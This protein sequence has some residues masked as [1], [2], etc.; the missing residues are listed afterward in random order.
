MAFLLWYKRGCCFMFLLLALTQA[1]AQKAISL[2]GTV[3]PLRQYAAQ[4]LQRYLYQLSGEWLPI[5]KQPV[6]EGFVIAAKNEGSLSTKTFVTD[7]IGDQGY[8]LKKLGNQLHI[9]ANTAV[10]CLYGVYGLLDD[11]YD[12]GFYFS[13]DVLP[14]QKKAFF[15]PEVNEE[16]SPS[17]YIRGFLPW[18]N[19]PQSATIYSWE[20]WR[21]II[22]QAAK[23][24]MNFIHIHNYNG[25]SGHNE[26]YHNFEYKGILSRVWMPTARTGHRWSMKGFDVKD[27]R[28]GAEDLVGD[29]DMGSEVGLH[30]ETLDNKAVFAKGVNLFQRVI[31][32]AHERGVKIGLGLDIDLIM[33]DYKTTPDDPEVIKAR[34]EQVLNDYPDL[35]Y[36]ILFISELINEQPEKL[37]QWRRIF[38]GMYRIVNSRPQHPRIA[39]AGWGLNAAIANDLPADVIAAPISSYSDGFEPGAIYGDR[40]YW[41]CPWMERDFFSSEYYYPYN[42]HLHNTVQAWQQR[43]PNMKGLYTLSWRLTDAVDPR[44]SFI[45]KAA[46]DADN[47]YKTAGAVYEEYARRNYGGRAASAIAG[48]LNNNEPASIATAECE[49]TAAFTGTAFWENQNLTNLLRFQFKKGA[50]SSSMLDYK[51]R[52]ALHNMGIDNAHSPLSDSCFGWIKEGSWVRYAGVDLRAGFDSMTYAAATPNTEVLVEVRLDSASGTMI[53]TLPLQ[54]TGGWHNWKEQRA[55]VQSVKGVH[56]V[57]FVVRTTQDHSVDPVQKAM[58][59]IHLIDSL[60]AL[61]NDAGQKTRM[62]W[63]KARLAAAAD[64]VRL[65]QYFPS[66]EKPGDLPG[67]FPSWVRNFTRRIS[68]ISSLGN[69]QSIQNRYV[70]ENYLAKEKELLQKATVKFPTRVKARGTK[71]GALVTW[72]NNEPA[73]KGFVVMADGKPLH[74]GWLAPGVRSFHHRANGQFKYQVA[75]VSFAGMFSEASEIS[76]C[77]AGNTDKEGPQIV[78]VSPPASL[79]GVEPFEIKASLLDNRGYAALHAVLY[80]RY[81]GEKTWRQSP[82]EWR[83]KAIFTARL[84]M[85]GAKAIEYYVRADDGS[86]TTV[87]P[88][89]APSLALTAV[90]TQQSPVSK[91]VSLL[92]KAEKDQLLWQTN[93][94]GNIAYFKLYRSRQ[95]QFRPSAATYVCYLPPSVSS[96]TP[97]G[98]DFDGQPLMGTYFYQVVAVGRQGREQAVAKPV[99]LL[100]VGKTFQ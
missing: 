16:K 87:Y 54:G 2:P 95:P 63:L 72:E 82:M 24:R 9:A 92:L 26:P 71:D 52:S 46:W 66:I 34:T 62:Q 51:N 78:L 85:Q 33:P 73:V 68:D 42:M 79:K 47:K 94:S 3:S 17:M 55:A 15:L 88:A 90:I 97:N 25:Q 39:V 99:A 69:V 30:N 20:D 18:T 35:D 57:Y 89:T 45:A 80:Y 31:A 64:H 59:Q 61:T 81:A 11:H 14:Q 70:Q 8:V 53:A 6:S 76:V 43:S 65:N 91:P 40:E 84:S 49:G 74:G 12:V 44:I 37:Q 4:E 13:G 86:N 93:G 22:D 41:G 38:D 21:Y 27:Y 56:N 32:Y 67:T 36:L 23:M 83:T 96:F 29:Y 5:I 77:S 7:R 10:G 50:E 98:F 60:S 1:L 75:A 58:A 19:F 100:H 28:F 48:I